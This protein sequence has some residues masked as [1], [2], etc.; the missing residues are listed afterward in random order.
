MTE[1]MVGSYIVMNITPRVPHDRSLMTIG[2]KCNSRKV[3]GFIATE[4]A[5]STDPGNTCL[6]SFPENDSNVYIHPVVHPHFLGRYFNA[7]NT[8]E[9]QNRMQKSDIDLENYWGT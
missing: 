5:G 7:C 1:W 4:G 8:I 9:N 3:L 2:H 6:Y